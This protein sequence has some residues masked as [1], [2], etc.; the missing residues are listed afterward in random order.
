MSPGRSGQGTSVII[1]RQE[2]DH[3]IHSPQTISFQRTDSGMY[4]LGWIFQP[5]EKHSSA[6]EMINDLLYNLAFK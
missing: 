6:L 3:R 2:H 1:Y 5:A 4:A